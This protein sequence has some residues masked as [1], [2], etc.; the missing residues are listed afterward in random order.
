MKIHS[1]FSCEWNPTTIKQTVLTVP[2][3]LLKRKNIL[4]K[5]KNS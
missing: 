1:L 3:I 4:A 2:T 5:H